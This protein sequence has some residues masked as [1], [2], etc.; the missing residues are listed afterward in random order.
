MSPFAP[1]F[2]MQY[3]IQSLCSVTQNRRSLVKIQDFERNFFLH[4]VWLPGKIQIAL[5]I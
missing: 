4:I 5:R 2:L 3:P 1:L